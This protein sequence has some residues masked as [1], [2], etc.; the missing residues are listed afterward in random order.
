MNDECE[1]VAR[2]STARFQDRSPAAP[3]T[4]NRK[5]SSLAI[6]RRHSLR[7]IRPGRATMRQAATFLLLTRLA[8]VAAFGL[9]HKKNGCLTADTSS[10]QQQLQKP[11]D[12]RAFLNRASQT[13]ALASSLM[14]PYSA[15]ASA[16]VSMDQAAVAP[17]SIDDNA[18]T[19]PPITQKVAFD[20]RI[21]R[22]DGTFYVRD[23]LPDTPENKVFYGRLVFGL[24]GTIAP[25]HVDNFL[26]YTVRAYNAAEIDS[27]KPSYGK[28]SF[29]RFDEATGLLEGGF[30]PSLEITDIGGGTS[31]RYG[32]SIIPAKLWIEK[33][34]G[35]EG[36]Q[37]ISH[38][39]KGLLTHKTLD[40]LPFFGITTRKAPELDS[41]HVVFGQ[42]LPDDSSNEFLR[43][44]RDV[45]PKYSM[46][47]PSQS[48]EFPTTEA[49]R[50]TN[51][52]ASRVFSA[53][54]DFFRGAAKSFGDGR[55]DKI[56]EGKLLRRVEVTKVEML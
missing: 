21:S 12:R 56:Y 5:A 43:L 27:P 39:G 30:I 33:S 11:R 2:Y 51:E 9:V 23:D 16:V 47:R 36:V 1:C 4:R 19:L 13:I 28:S 3:E 52:L 42:L 25:V 48:D 14:V 55:I 26:K 24:F 34:S 20:V 50:A 22:Q 17:Q 31:L 6:D 49:E 35:S 37:K 44:V 8:I 54:R 18:S 41:S 46:D 7:H 38:Q 32:S 45:I 40:L 29:N 15:S 53:Q 10:N